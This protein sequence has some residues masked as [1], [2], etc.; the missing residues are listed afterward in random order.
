MVL[1]VWMCLDMPW[2]AKQMVSK[3]SEKQDIIIVKETYFY[4]MLC[5]VYYV[6]YYKITAYK[7]LKI[8]EI[9]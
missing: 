3:I 8:H 1:N 2:L 9:K 5:M 6:P 4:D 7:L